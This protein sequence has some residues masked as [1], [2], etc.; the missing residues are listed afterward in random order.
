MATTVVSDIIDHYL[1]LFEAKSFYF[2]MF[3]PYKKW[4]GQDH[5]GGGQ[6]IYKPA[7]PS[8]EVKTADILNGVN[9]CAYLKD[10]FQQFH[11]K[12]IQSDPKL[13]PDFSDFAFGFISKI[14]LAGGKKAWLL[15]ID[16]NCDIS[17][18]NLKKVRITLKLLK[19][20]SGL[21]VN[22]GNSY[23]FYADTPFTDYQAWRK[24][25]QGGWCGNKYLNERTWCETA[26]KVIGNNWPRLTLQQG[27]A[28]LRVN[29]CGPK[30]LPLTVVEYFQGGEIE[31]FPLKKY[32]C[33]KKQD[34][35]YG[36]AIQ[37]SDNA[38]TDE[39]FDQILADWPIFSDDHE[40]AKF[41]ARFCQLPCEYQGRTL[42]CPK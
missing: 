33:R 11:Q 4:V 12:M 1:C 2:A 29:Q 17:R 9:I 40:H 10:K 24:F 13:N 23:H 28:M 39:K 22:S 5:Y 20:G 8:F 41:I 21:I 32:P 16:F 31:E 6:L 18:E 14:K 36:A 7:F 35:A 38:K 26:H 3:A 15:L 19:T 42:V 27:F 34:I 37:A 30:P 25:Y